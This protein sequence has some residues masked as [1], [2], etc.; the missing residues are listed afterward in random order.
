MEVKERVGGAINLLRWCNFPFEPNEIFDIIKDTRTDELLVVMKI[1][2]G[3][4]G[5]IAWA[6][7][8]QRRG[9]FNFDIAVSKSI[10][11]LFVGFTTLGLP[12]T[13]FPG[14]EVRQ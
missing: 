7:Y 12:I 9:F 8:G 6:A 1:S 2:D 14:Y 5:R 4:A 11:D 10:G 13:E 3:A